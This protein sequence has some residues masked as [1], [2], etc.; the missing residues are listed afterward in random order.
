MMLSR[1][2]SEAI[3]S[4]T[5]AEWSD[6]E[7]EAFI[8]DNPDVFDMVIEGITLDDAIDLMLTGTTVEEALELLEK[9]HPDFKKSAGGRFAG[10]GGGNPGNDPFST[11]PLHD[12]SAAGSGGGRPNGR[13]RTGRIPKGGCKC[14]NYVCVCKKRDG[15]KV[16]IDMSS[17]KAKKKVY[18]ER[19]RATHAKVHAKANDR[20][21]G[22]RP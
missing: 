4:P 18:M 16:T 8:D 11:Q 14:H 9:G 2:L 17:Y 20:G 21:T 3:A 5:D 6:A 15:G 13:V 12:T 7:L 22:P 10:S 1:E 19:W